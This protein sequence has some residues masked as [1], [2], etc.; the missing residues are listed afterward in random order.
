M[1]SSRTYELIR[2]PLEG[3]FTGAPRE[4]LRAYKEWF[5]GSV[6]NRVVLLTA[7]VRSKEPAWQP[8]CTRESLQSLEH[9]FVTGVETR[10]RTP[11]EIGDIYDKAPAWFRSV[12]V[13]EWELTEQTFSRCFD[14]G[15]YF[16]RCLITAHPSLSWQQQFGSQNDVNY[17]HVVVVGFKNGMVCNPVHIATTL[18]YGVAS[19]SVGP[20]RLYELFRTWSE[21]S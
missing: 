9:W 6:D 20:G 14:V 1:S 13:S 5:L 18:A 15:M 8:D 21:F 4:Q 2:P 17:G 7:G 16:G 19:E 10:K 12:Q 11:S 3:P